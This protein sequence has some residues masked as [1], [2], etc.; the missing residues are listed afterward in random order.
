MVGKLATTSPNIGDRHH[1]TAPCLSLIR[2]IHP[3][4]SKNR[5]ARRW[6]QHAA[7]KRDFGKS[8]WAGS[9]VR[10]HQPRDWAEGGMTA[11]G[12]SRPFVASN[13]RIVAPRRV[14]I[15]RCL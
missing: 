12:P 14:L 10:L 4:P 7:K 11:S 3:L 2:T 15:S 5:D 9:E 13:I 1:I 6:H 8:R